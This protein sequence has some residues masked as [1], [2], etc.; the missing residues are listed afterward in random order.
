[1]RTIVR[2]SGVSLVFI[3]L[4]VG[5]YA[6]YRFTLAFFGGVPEDFSLARSRGAFIAQTIVGTSNDLSADLARVEE[7]DRTYNYTEALVLT[8]ELAKQTVEIRTRAVELAAELEI[9]TR[10][11]P[12]IRSSEARALALESVTNRLALINHLI[13]YSDALLQLVDALRGRFTGTYT[14]AQVNELIDRVNGEIVAINELDSKAQET[15]NKFDE[16]TR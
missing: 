8:S 14:D 7:L 1:M 6:A 4:V 10:A 15:M 2:R 12:S 5:G 13:T 11:M 9:M 3:I 16:L